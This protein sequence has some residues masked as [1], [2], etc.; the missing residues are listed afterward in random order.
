MNRTANFQPPVYIIA[1]HT[2]GTVCAGVTSD[3]PRRA[4]QHREGAAEGFTS[5]K[6]C[7]RLA[8]FELHRA[9]E[10]ATARKKQIKGGSR[11]AKLALIKAGNPD[12]RDLFFYLKA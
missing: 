8:W 5:R 10:Q 6:N 12:W 11:K 9:M 7:K 2:G 4:W 3:L 1:N